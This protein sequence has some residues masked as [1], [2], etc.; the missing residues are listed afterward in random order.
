MFVS[1]SEQIRYDE[2]RENT[3]GE[4]AAKWTVVG[5]AAVVLF[6]A[7]YFALHVFA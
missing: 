5:V 4:R 7:L 2:A 1:L 3:P 6:A